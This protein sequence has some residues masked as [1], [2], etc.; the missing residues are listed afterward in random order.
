MAGRAGARAITSFPHSTEPSPDPARKTKDSPRFP[1]VSAEPILPPPK[2]KPGAGLQQ[3][4]P[5]QPLSAPEGSTPF[6]ALPGIPPSRGISAPCWPQSEDE[7]RVPH[8]HPG[9]R[10]PILA[11]A[12]AG[13][14]GR[15]RGAG[16][17]ARSTEPGGSPGL[18]AERSGAGLT[19]ASPGL[20]NAQETETRDK[21]K[22]RHHQAAGA[23]RPRPQDPRA[24]AEPPGGG[25]RRGAPA[26]P[27][28]CI[29][30]EAAGARS[31][32][33][34]RVSHL[35]IHYR[36]DLSGPRAAL[37][38]SQAFVIPTCVLVSLGITVA[39]TTFWDAKALCSS[40]MKGG[41][42]EQKKE[43]KKPTRK[44]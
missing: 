22:H 15:V 11:V 29:D 18:R 19:A 26:V 23:C 14:A 42:G 25:A 43:R 32:Q 7:P 2:P 16:G 1:T 36:G 28:R 31:G 5:T 27:F 39:A 30:G 9:A 38:P 35:V 33:I 4:S 44:E 40:P 6:R 37:S 20:G 10:Q 41:E 3:R 12:V 17:E 13:G 8:T 24:G 21:I 34:Q